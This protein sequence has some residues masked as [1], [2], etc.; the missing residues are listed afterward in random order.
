M[1]ADTVKSSGTICRQGQGR[2]QLMF[3]AKVL[4]NAL[5]SFTRKQSNQSFFLADD[6][7]DPYL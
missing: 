1:N 7:F 6:R 4:I 3:I 5:V 2:C